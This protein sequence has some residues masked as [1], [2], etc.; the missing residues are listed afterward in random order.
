MLLTSAPTSESTICRVI[1]YSLIPESTASHE[2]DSEHLI[3]VHVSHCLA[4]QNKAQIL[5]QAVTAHEFTAISS[6]SLREERP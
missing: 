3:F 5:E 6:L 2:Q 1:K 4:H